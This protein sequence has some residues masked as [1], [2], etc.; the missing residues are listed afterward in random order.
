MAALQKF[1]LLATQCAMAR[2]PSRGPA[3]SAGCAGG[4]PVFRL[5]RRN[6]LSR[7]LGCRRGYGAPVEPPDASRRSGTLRDLF[8]SSPPPA[9]DAEHS[10]GVGGAGGGAWLGVDGFA[11]GGRAGGRGLPRFRSRGLRHRLLRRPWRPM[12]VAIQE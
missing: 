6:K 5:R 7:L 3:A 1:K 2:S 9:L 8:V 11:G 4:S 12:L 10:G